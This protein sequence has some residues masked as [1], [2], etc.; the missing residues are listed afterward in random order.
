[1]THTV[2]P[3][4]YGT[5]V[6][7]LTFRIERL[8][9]GTPDRLWRYLTD[10]DLR[11]LWLASGEMDL[12]VGAPFELVWQNDRL[13]DD[14]GQRP[15]E[16]GEEHRMASRILV[17][18]PPRRL[19]FTWNDTGEVALDLAPQEDGVLLTVTHR[20]LSG[21]TGLLQ[22]SAGWHA[23]LDILEARLDGRPFGSF[24]DH[25]RSLKD[26]YAARLPE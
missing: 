2:A 6:E 18:D 1:M 11:Q 3:S 24:W 15:A 7:P 19:V 16:F 9:P 8:L 25:W 5:L 20:R 13:C 26:S 4:A 14:P 23:H 17:C 10:S 21:R 22:V 12:K